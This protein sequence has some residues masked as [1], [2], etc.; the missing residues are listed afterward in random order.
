MKMLS[1]YTVEFY[2]V[3]KNNRLGK[4]RWNW[5][6]LLYL[7]DQNSET[8]EIHVFSQHSAWFI[9]FI[10]ICINGYKLR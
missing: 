5:E 7:R 2:S 8:Q 6:I 3:V 9:T 1:R 10:C 4:N